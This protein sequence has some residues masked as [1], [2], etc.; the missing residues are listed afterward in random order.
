MSNEYVYEPKSCK[1][2]LSKFKYL[3]TKEQT[4]FDEHFLKN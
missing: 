3:E 1:R 4:G 2:D